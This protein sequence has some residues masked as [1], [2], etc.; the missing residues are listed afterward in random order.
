[1]YGA[2]EEN[3]SGFGG[4]GTGNNREVEEKKLYKDVDRERRAAQKG[5]V[6]VGKGKKNPKGLYML[7]QGGEGG[8]VG[9]KIDPTTSFVKNCR[10]I[11][12]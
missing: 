11:R 6:L 7:I 9:G 10:E 5:G 4:G 1:V 2:S 8:V 12:F 3:P